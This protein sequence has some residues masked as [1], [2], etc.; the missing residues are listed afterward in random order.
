[1]PPKRPSEE[2]RPTPPVVPPNIADK[3][4]ELE[5]RFQ[6]SIT[7]QNIYEK[8]MAGYPAIYLQTG[9]DNRSQGDLKVAA[10]KLERKFFIWSEGAG[11]VDAS[12]R[13]GIKLKDSESHIGC[14]AALLTHEPRTPAIY[15]LRLFHHNLKDPQ[16]QVM[17]LDLVVKFKLSSKMLVITSPVINIPTEIEKEITLVESQ[18][19][20][21]FQLNTV[22]NGIIK[23][24][25]IPQNLLPTEEQRREIV[26]SALGLTVSEAENALTLSFIRPRFAGGK[27]NETGNWWDSKIV[28]DEKCLALKK[29]GLLEYIHTTADMSMVGG[30]S[31]LKTWIRKRKRGFTDEAKAY[32]GLAPPK[33]VLLVGPPGT[34]KSLSA[35]TASSELGIPLLKLDMGKILGHLVGKSEENMRL[36][37]QIAEALSPC[38][39]WMDEIEKA[40]AGSRAGASDTGVGSRL[41]AFLLTWMQE[42]T[43]S[44]FVYATCNEVTALDSALIRKGRFDEI[45]SVDLPN[46]EERKEIF[47]IHMNKVGRK[48]LIDSNII[49][50]NYFAEERTE[51]FTGAEIEGCIQEALYTSFDRNEELTKIDLVQAFDSTVPVSQSMEKQLEEMRKWCKNNTRSASI[52]PMEVP[53]EV[54]AAGRKAAVN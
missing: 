39:L 11:V 17:L 38:I 8:G 53:E 21:K 2:E 33:G 23:A 26:K 19:P 44:V 12:D 15:M 10:W 25:E 24:S 14:L 9:E 7:A 48:H 27:R 43:S 36:A 45:F 50:V 3:E 35:K 46:V 34:G 28:M 41:L 5:E 20:N 31:G 22:L 30:L 6:Q 37:I 18:L 4:R 40:L 52:K 13:A 49:D 47:R 16:V 1:M 54:Y 32:G 51:G 29:S 42:K